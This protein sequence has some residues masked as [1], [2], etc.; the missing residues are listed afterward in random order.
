MEFVLLIDARVSN[1]VVDQSSKQQVTSSQPLVS[2]HATQQNPPHKQ[3]S[4][5]QLQDD[6]C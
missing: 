4:I 3:P 1:N 6:L 5:I 2:K